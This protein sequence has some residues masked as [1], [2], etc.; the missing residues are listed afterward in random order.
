MPDRVVGFICSRSRRPGN[1]CEPITEADME[2]AHDAAWL[3]TTRITQDRQTPACQ[4]PCPGGCGGWVPAANAPCLLC[5]YRSNPLTAEAARSRA[6]PA[7]HP[8]RS[9]P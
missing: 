7:D 3:M 9:A 8:R 5:W 2:A 1:R 6:L 4:Y